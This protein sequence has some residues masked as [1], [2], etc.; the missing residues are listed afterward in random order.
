MVKAQ[1]ETYDIDQ[2]DLAVIVTDS[3]PE[4]NR[5]GLYKSEE[6]EAHEVVFAADDPRIADLHK[7]SFN[8]D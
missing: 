4:G 5:K 1:T 7:V 3:N 2:D 6:C 8:H